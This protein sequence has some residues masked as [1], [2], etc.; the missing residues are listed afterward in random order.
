MFEQI[1]TFSVPTLTHCLVARFVILNRIFRV[2]LQGLAA[3]L[4]FAGYP[5]H[6]LF[7]IGAVIPF[8]VFVAVEEFGVIHFGGQVLDEV[9]FEYLVLPTEVVAKS[10]VQFFLENV[11]LF[12]LVVQILDLIQFCYHC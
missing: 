7:R 6:A 11:V 8:A 2:L 5:V 10:L 3:T 1:L 4:V 12:R 9:L